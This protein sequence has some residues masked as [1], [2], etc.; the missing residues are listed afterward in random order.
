MA[1]NDIA[2]LGIK[3]DP[4][5]A[6]T[7][8]SRAKRAILGIGAA[9][10]RIK[11]E[12]FS[13]QAGLIGLGGGLV[14]RSFVKTA[15]SLEKLQVQLKT[16]TGSAE[17][18]DKAF[19]LLTEFT[20]K[21]PYEIDQV[22]TAF[23]KLK[24]YGL[25]PTEKSLTAFGNT[26]SAMGKSLDQMI[27]AVADAATMEFER[28]KEFGIKAKQEADVVKFTF[29]G[30]TTEVKKNADAIKGYLMGI[31]ETNFGGAMAAQMETWE[32]QVSNLRGSWTLFKKE[33]MDA[34]PFTVL[35]EM[36]KALSNQ[37]F[38]DAD[39]VAAT[40]R[41]AGESIT[42]MM[43]G[44]LRTT[45]KLIDLFSGEL[46]LL[47]AIIGKM[48]EGFQALPR[49]VQEVGIFGALVGGRLGKIAL[50]G[51]MLAGKQ[52]GD[53]FESIMESI[54]KSINRHKREQWFGKPGEVFSL[55]GAGLSQLGKDSNHA[56]TFIEKFIGNTKELT[57]E[58]TNAASAAG[59][60]GN[61]SQKAVDG[62]LAS[63]GEKI[64]DLSKSANDFAAVGAQ[65]VDGFAS[66]VSNKLIEALNTG[67]TSF[68]DFANS[69]IQDF[70][71]MIIQAYILRAATAFTEKGGLLETLGSGVGQAIGSSFGASSGYY[72]PKGLSNMNVRGGYGDTLIPRGRA[73]GGPVSAGTP[74]LVGERGPELMVPGGSGSI[75]PNSDLGGATNVT[76]NITT[77][78]QSTV[79]AEIMQ[80]MPMIANNVKQAVAESRMR[81]GQFSSAMGV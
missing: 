44:T 33:V 36:L 37:L 68:T 1:A 79:R 48:W 13:L 54:G 10:S 14:V 53:L 17:N 71:R 50:A 63:F 67:K 45:A 19:S 29:Q 4:R 21:T 80:M 3:V 51:M 56:S 46:N 5:G 15:A 52:I 28:L 72:G 12:I 70:Q 38:G 31:G 74:Y 24:A 6:I 73:H 8:S 69:I 11:G 57:D 64:G 30:V 26:A 20:T 34:G 78:I 65:M 58:L 61:A 76:L 47:V 35:K 39:S 55:F 42:N 22:V 62:P 16:V 81:G 32:G 7:G 43:F 75:V 59:D 41:K 25:D 27:E 23:T 9:A 2:T 66:G 77:G 60:L 18:A 40:A 49:W